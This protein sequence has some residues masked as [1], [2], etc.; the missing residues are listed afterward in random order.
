MN[1]KY[2]ELKTYLGFGVNKLCLPGKEAK[3]RIYIN[4]NFK[5]V[6]NRFDGFRNSEKS[7]LF[8]IASTIVSVI[9][10]VS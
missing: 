3:R 4:R 2:K 10:R 7:Y 5:I 8:K 9:T 1:V 6:L